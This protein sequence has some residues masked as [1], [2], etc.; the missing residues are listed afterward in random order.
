MFY[1]KHKAKIVPHCILNGT[2][3]S[4]KA[5]WDGYYCA[6]GDKDKK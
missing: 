2:I 6:D 3:E 1:D 5:F 4:K